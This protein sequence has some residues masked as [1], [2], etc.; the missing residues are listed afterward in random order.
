MT[1][2]VPPEPVDIK[3]AMKRLMEEMMGEPWDW[4]SLAVWYGNKLPQYLWTIQGWKKGLSKIG[5][6]W[7]S[8]LSLL[9]KH[10]HE[11]IRWATEE[12]SWSDL[13]S[14]IETDLNSPTISK[15]YL[16]PREGLAHAS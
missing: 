4:Q 13:I 10:T 12:V 6:S 9:S 2:K 15:I 5:W 16:T 11:M 14:V 8:F 3:N 7:Q 1:I